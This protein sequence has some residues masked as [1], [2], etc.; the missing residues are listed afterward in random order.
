MKRLR[1]VAWLAGV[2][3]CVMGVSCAILA[4]ESE[5]RILE[6]QERPA[7]GAA[8]GRDGRPCLQV[9]GAGTAV[10]LG[11]RLFYFEGL[12]RGYLSDWLASVFIGGFLPHFAVHAAGHGMGKLLYELPVTGVDGAWT[13][14][15]S[16]ATGTAV[17][18]ALSYLT[19]LP[20]RRFDFAWRAGGRYA[21][22]ALLSA[23]SV[24]YFLQALGLPVY[25]YH[26]YL[27]LLGMR[28]LEAAFEAVHQL[29]SPLTGSVF[30]PLSGLASQLF[31][32]KALFPDS[33]QDG[34]GYELHR[35]GGERAATGP[36]VYHR[37]AHVMATGQLDIIRLIPSR[38]DPGFLTVAF[39]DPRWG[40]Q[41]TVSVRVS[42]EAVSGVTWLSS[43]ISGQRPR[44]S[45]R[46][47]RSAL[48]PVVIGQVAD[49]LT[50]YNA[51]P[52]L[53]AQRHLEP[54]EEATG[55]AAAMDETVFS[56]MDSSSLRRVGLASY[57][58]SAMASLSGRDLARIR[59]DTDHSDFVWQE[60]E[61]HPVVRLRWYEGAQPGLSLHI[62]VADGQAEGS[63]DL[64]SGPEQWW[65]PEWIT[66]LLL[67]EVAIRGQ[68]AGATLGRWGA[69]CLARMLGTRDKTEVVFRRLQEGTYAE[70]VAERR[71]EAGVPEQPVGVERMRQELADRVVDGLQVLQ[72]DVHLAMEFDG[73]AAPAAEIEVLEELEAYP[74]PAGAED[75]ARCIVCFE[76]DGDLRA[77]PGCGNPICMTCLLQWGRTF[78]GQRRAT[79]QRRARRDDLLAPL[80]NIDCP[81]RCATPVRARVLR[82]NA[83]D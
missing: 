31:V 35:L 64:R 54:D 65:V 69:D 16:A 58:Y 80:F 45:L 78:A 43:A 77:M 9:S 20:V 48:S 32:V 12:G 67:A 42:Q 26:F 23:L 46:V 47:V 51:Q 37:L 71:R 44:E 41:V 4:V 33:G 24:P 72:N 36:D 15:F 66:R 74:A 11:G 75:A 27:G 39:H 68:T 25:R 7:Y 63:Q 6:G 10:T 14:A 17:V 70:F 21:L 22:P 73:R 82:W 83:D 38:F 29:Y 34:A 49:A 18:G 5:A 2:W 53:E 81:I 57:T 52:H 28:G 13:L 50:L 30:V 60:R 56:G 62:A 8:V 79:L 3:L 55:E 40:R 19:Q 1:S 61:G 76:A 59:H